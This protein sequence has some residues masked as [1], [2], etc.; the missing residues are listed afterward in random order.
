[1][2]KILFISIML[3]L[4]SLAIGQVHTSFGAIY[5]EP[6]NS[7]YAVYSNSEGN[8]VSEKVN[9]YKTDAWASDIY[10]KLTYYK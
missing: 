1:M 5:Y 10:H 8:L 9:T 7:V 2:K 4:S 6:N 3:Y